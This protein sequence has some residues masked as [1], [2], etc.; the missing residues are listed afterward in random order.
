MEQFKGLQKSL[1]IWTDSADLDKRVEQ[2]KTATGGEVAVENVH[3]LSFS[4]YANSSFDLIVIECAQ[5]TDNY[6]KLLHMLK[7]SGKL[8][9]FSFIGPASS[10]LQE[11]KLSGFINCSEGTDTLTAEKP[12]YETGSSARLSF[13][14][15][16]ASALNVWKI[17]GD[18]E[19]LI[20]EE[21]LL[22]EE[23]KQKPDPAGLKVCSTT[24][25]RKA[26]KNCSCGLAEELESE[27]QTATASENAKSS[28]GNCYLGDAFRCSTCPYLGMPAF[29]PGEKVQLADNLLKSDI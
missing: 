8:H 5:L 1:Y 21:D 18:D 11:I 6:V 28:C 10:L 17:S 15:K 23:D 9:L 29:K 25:K 14:K 27:K 13:A 24:G 4:S 2:L 26:C 16:N 7:P 19:E 22:D 20:D 3:R 12:G